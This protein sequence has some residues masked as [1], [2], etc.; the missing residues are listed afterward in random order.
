MHDY[1]DNSLENVFFDFGKVLNSI[2]S[3]PEP[4]RT[5]SHRIGSGRSH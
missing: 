2:V 1:P 3:V 4:P 5:T